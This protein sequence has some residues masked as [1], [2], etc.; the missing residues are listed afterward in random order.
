MSGGGRLGGAAATADRTERAE[1]RKTKSLLFS[2]I[3]H[4]PTYLSLPTF[5]EKGKQQ[6][7]RL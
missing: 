5:F 2:I 3:F 7:L 1:V 6:G 4:S